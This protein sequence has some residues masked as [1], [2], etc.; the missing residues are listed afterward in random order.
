[1]YIRGPGTAPFT[2]P[3]PHT[4]ISFKAR[5]RERDIICTCIYSRQDAS[6]VAS[7]QSQQATSSQSQQAPPAISDN[8]YPSG[9]SKKSRDHRDM[10]KVSGEPKE[11][12]DSK[13]WSSLLDDALFEPFS[14][15]HSPE[16]SF[17]LYDDDIPTGKRVGH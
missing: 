16:H 3:L 4:W 14:P 10:E 17:D 12:D 5:E 6:S 1:M 7:E 15:D 2:R 11:E 8:V 9:W 13:Q